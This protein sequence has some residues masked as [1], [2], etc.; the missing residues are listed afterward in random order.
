MRIKDPG[1]GRETGGPKAEL[2]DG[3][4]SITAEAD[5]KPYD[6]CASGGEEGERLRYC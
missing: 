6:G 5:C 2:V 4:L 3:E 1:R